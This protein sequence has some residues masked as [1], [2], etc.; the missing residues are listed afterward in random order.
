MVTQQN[1]LCVAH[2]RLLAYCP[3]LLVPVVD[4]TPPPP[5]KWRLP[6]KEAKEILLETISQQTIFSIPIALNFSR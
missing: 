2:S 5:K 3:L 1:H 4:V 6:K